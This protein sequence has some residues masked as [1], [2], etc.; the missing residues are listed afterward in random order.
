[1][2][3]TE[4]LAQAIHE[5]YIREQREEGHTV[6]DN[7]SMAAWEELPEHLK[8]SSR[9]QADD[10]D[11]KLRSIGCEIE[12]STG[13]APDHFGIAPDELEPL[14]RMEHDRWWRER[15]SEGWT[16]ASEKDVEAKESPYLVPYEDLPDEIKEYDRN[17]VRLI[18]V[19]LARAG[20]RVVR[21][22]TEK[23][24]GEEAGE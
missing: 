5:E 8:E 14:A 17:V 3:T 21:V 7:P 9:R 15:E 11:K 13:R 19:V 23:R 16:F 24:P 4:R 10:I 20:L 18:P 22:G 6:E 12:D 1:M 2:R